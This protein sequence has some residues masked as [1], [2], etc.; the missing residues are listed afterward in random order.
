ML[1]RKKIEKEVESIPSDGF[2]FLCK[3][4]GYPQSMRK[5]MGFVN[6]KF[7]KNSGLM[8][9]LQ[10][11]GKQVNKSSINGFPDNVERPIEVV[12]S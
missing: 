10:G 5:E 9:S 7:E 12:L 1:E 11:M 2:Y 4:Q 6:W 8:Q 3:G